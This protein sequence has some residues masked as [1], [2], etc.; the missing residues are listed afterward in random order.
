MEMNLRILILEDNDTDAAMVV[1]VL[2]KDNLKF[3]HRHAIDQESYVKLLDEFQPDVI[4]SDNN[5]PTFSGA[6]A[7]Q[8]F[9]ERKMQIPF[10]LVTGAVSE[11]FAA[12]IIKLGADDYILK[13]RM[14][15]LP[16]AISAALKQ[17]DTE[18]EKQ[19]TI[20]QLTENEK[21]YRT[22]IERVS[23]GYIALDQ[24]WN[25]MYI[26]SKAEQYFEE[27]R[28]LLGKNIWKTLD[29]KNND[30]LYLSCLRS[31]RLRENIQ[32]AEYAINDQHWVRVNI[33]PS[34]SGVSM[35][36]HDISSEKKAQEEMKLSN[37][38]F[39]LISG[40][41]TDMV[42]DWN[43]QTNMLWWNKNY[44]S[45]FGYTDPNI[46]QY[47]S[48][49][50]E[51]IYPA[52]RE[53]VVSSIEDC[54]KKGKP[55]WYE[56][57][58]FL[59]ADQTVLFVSDSGYVL[60]NESGEPYRMVGAMVDVTEQKLAKQ[61]L[62]YSNQANKQLAERMSAIL[63]TLPANIALIDELG[64]IVEVNDAWKIFAI[65]NGN[66]GDH[67]GVG[68][69][70]LQITE[71]ST[72]G[73]SNIDANE[74]ISGVKSVLNNS[75]STFSYEYS[76]VTPGYSRWYKM[77]VTRLE[78]KEHA[79][80][81]VMNI[82][83]TEM[84]NAELAIRKSNERLQTI[85][86][87]TNDALW[88][89]DLVTD[90][91]WWN[92]SAFK[93]AGYSSDQ[94][95]PDIIDW[96][97]QV[98][99]DDRDLLLNRMKNYKETDLDFFEEEYRYLINDAGYGTVLNRAYI[100]RDEHQKPIRVVGAFMDITL[101]KAA[102]TE[103][104]RSTEQLRE[105]SLHLQDIREEERAALSREVHDVLGQQLTSFKMDLHWLGRRLK[106]LPEEV[107]EKMKNISLAIDATIKTVRKIA[108]E[109]RPGILDDLGL[110]AALEWH[111]EEFENRS[112]IKVNFSS[113]IN[114]VK[115]QPKI[116]IAIFRIFQELLTNV[117][118]HAKATE[119][120]ASLGI[121]NKALCLKVTDNGQ[122][123]SK[124]KIEAKKTMGMLGMRER[125]LLLSGKYE[126]NSEPGKGTSTLITVPIDMTIERK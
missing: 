51:A 65:G 58:R 84:K 104:K 105:L 50:S 80:A 37:D 48:A 32:I 64:N 113:E 107:K 111:S 106:D 19:A 114:N 21:K 2:Q 52:D 121:A 109:L 68:D 102:E 103:L 126:V 11:E 99:P 25:L 3:E 62:E 74:L 5:L 9:N 12:N 72:M 38:R 54:I 30:Q 44:Y 29:Y 119:V 89:W 125:T 1:R 31:M 76:C 61:K 33:Y 55:Y 101:R 26:N 70:Y 75:D 60:F 92:E 91:V 4:L 108:S 112:G 98:H 14:A 59:K 67:F 90:E 63:N 100:L 82:D 81:V 73:I 110:V 115:I 53:R 124:E 95:I 34:S 42:W 22:L 86:K 23:D 83:I 8:I 16:S 43:L 47:I 39:E 71:F 77:I 116:A 117:A 46:P 120:N 7:L 49:W 57:Y 6:E 28:K 94:P 18:R 69:N 20:V 17:R 118:R 45:H 36:L 40:A 66:T 93:L 41:T 79:G 87:A 78:E 88:D 85:S 96:I 97:S 122:G 24:D 13:D 123:F 10:I 56:E 27:S 15:R 35:Y